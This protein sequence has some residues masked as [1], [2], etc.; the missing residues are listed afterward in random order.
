MTR[1][2]GRAPLRQLS[3]AGALL[4]PLLVLSTGDAS[5]QPTKWGPPG[6]Q[7]GAQPGLVPPPPMGKS[8]TTTQQQLERSEREDAGRGLE[9]FWIQAEGG[10]AYAAASTLANDKLFPPGSAD[11]GGAGVIGLAAGGRVLFF[12][13]GL[14]A[15]MAF[16]SAY[17]LVTVVPEVGAHV[18]LG[19]WEPYAFLGAGYAALSGVQKRG[20]DSVSVAGLDARLGLGVDRYLTPTFSVGGLFTADLLFLRRD[21]LAENASDLA[22]AKGSGTGIAVAGTVVV[23]LHF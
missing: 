4:L 9:W 19:V 1:Q 20:T 10:G 8:P 7:P 18:P 22:L 17:R 12:T 15:R 5:A 6:P 3:L 14:R 11:G 2:L 13:F 16:L 23:G 21:K